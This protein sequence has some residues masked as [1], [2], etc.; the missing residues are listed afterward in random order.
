M[1]ISLRSQREG[2]KY[3]FRHIGAIL[4]F[5]LIFHIN[6]FAQLGN[7]WQEIQLLDKNDFNNSYIDFITDDIKD[8][9]NPES[10]NSYPSTNLFDGYLKTCWVAGSAK[11]NNNSFLYVKLPD[12]IELDKVILN[13]FSG[14]GK[15]ENLHYANARPQRIKLTLFAAVYPKGFSTEVASLYGVKE[16][17]VGRTICLA[18]TF[19]VQSF[20]LNLDKNALLVFQ[21][22]LLN[23]TKYWSIS[24]ESFAGM[25]LP[26]TFSTSYIL[27]MEILDSY[28]GS[29]YDDVCISEIFFNDR[30]ISPVPDKYSQV[31]DIY[32]REDNTLMADFFDNKEVVIFK[33]S[34][35]V[36]TYVDWPENSN[37]A[38][39]L[40]VPNDEYGGVSRNEELYTLIDLKN[41][42]LVGSRFEKCTGLTLMF[43]S[44]N[45]DENGKVYIENEEMLIELK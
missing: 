41:R 9:F 35:S 28:P 21:T 16:Y 30:F 32:I 8:Y 10:E 14:Y 27:K 15:S 33:D 12:K 37:W 29:K 43:Q 23:Q 39:L 13:I 18:D 31:L 7:E 5:A 26:E 40:Y 38:M 25:S 36:F 6:I 20:P 3:F 2:F 22:E 44:L 45:R 17:P 24:S 11:N 19:G 42:E 4:F 1:T 34:S